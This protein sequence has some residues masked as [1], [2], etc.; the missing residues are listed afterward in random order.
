MVRSKAYF[1][2][3]SAISRFPCENPNIHQAIFLFTLFI[4]FVKLSRH[5]YVTGLIRIQGDSESSLGQIGIRV[6]PRRNPN[7]G[8]N[9][10]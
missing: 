3:L 9:L 8:F 10:V 1:P 2:A 4:L 7:S 5:I 6:C